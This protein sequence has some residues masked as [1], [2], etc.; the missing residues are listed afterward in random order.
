MATIPLIRN[1]NDMYYRYQMPK[2]IAKIEGSGNGIRT[3]VTNMNLISKAINRPATHITK[4]FGYELGAQVKMEEKNN[5]YSVNGSHDAEKLLSLLYSFIE[6][7]VLCSKCENPETDLS[8]AKKLITLKCKA[9]GATTTISERTHRLT[10]YITNHAEETKKESKG[11]SKEKK[12]NGKASE[13]T[14]T[15]ETQASKVADDDFDDN[16]NFSGE[17]LKPDINILADEFKSIVKVDS[18]DNCEKF[19]QMIKEKLDTGLLNDVKVQKELLAEATSLQ[20]RD[21][22]TL[23]LC[24][25]LFNENILEQIS[26]HKILLLRFC[27]ENLKAQKYLL[28]GIEKIIEL[29]PKLLANTPKILKEFYD[30]EI[31]EEEVLIDWYGKP[32]KKYVSKDLAKSIRERA[33]PLIKWLKEA[34]VE[35]DSDNGEELKNGG[36]GKP[37]TNNSGGDDDEDEEEDDDDIGF[38]HRVVGIHVE[39]VK[40]KEEQVD[41]S[42]IDEI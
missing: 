2:L 7:F 23:A 18:A 29:F 38:S 8:V 16:D 39:T 17:D 28:G 4:F 13:G 14:N 21:K 31:L 22:S 36:G 40:T 19:C 20:I 34:E 25:A 32:S 26:T 15:N 12:K 35:E 9:C 11:K 27:V 10:T 33:F 41:D 37:A 6:K 24:K 30:K 5:I 3:V 1:K 42:F